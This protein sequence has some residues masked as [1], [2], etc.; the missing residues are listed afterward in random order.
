MLFQAMNGVL[1]HDHRSVNDHS[2]VDS[3]RLIRFA[4][5]PNS[6]MLMKL[7]SMA[8]E[9]TEAVMSAA[10]TLPRKRKKTTVTRMNP[11]KRFF[12]TVRIVPSMTIDRS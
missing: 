11:S 8:K 3:P 9:I 7:M 6:R 10:R 1:H 4:L 2:E 5:I 12:V